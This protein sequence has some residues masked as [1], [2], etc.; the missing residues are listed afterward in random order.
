MID[1]DVP[2]EHYITIIVL[3]SVRKI[4]TLL[5]RQS[6]LFFCPIPMIDFD[7]PFEHLVFFIIHLK[8]IDI[9]T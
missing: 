8:V 6:F 2:F 7:V 5:K 1:F 3:Q 9:V 4:Q